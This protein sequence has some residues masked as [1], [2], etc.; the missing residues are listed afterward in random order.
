LLNSS[1]NLFY[2]PY[3]DSGI[4][5]DASLARV[6]RPQR[7]DLPAPGTIR[8]HALPVP[9]PGQFDPQGPGIRDDDEAKLAQAGGSCPH[10]GELAGYVT[11][12]VRILTGPYGRRLDDWTTVQR[13]D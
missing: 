2:Y 8:D 9:R 7:P 6:A 5:L 3:R 10:L 1:I 11:E 4:L 12:S 13:P